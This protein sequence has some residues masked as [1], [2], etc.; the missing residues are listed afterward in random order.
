[1]D[2]TMG[3]DYFGHSRQKD[4]STRDAEWSINICI[5]EAGCNEKERIMQ[6]SA[7]LCFWQCQRQQAAVWIRVHQTRPS[8]WGCGGTCVSDNTSTAL[9]TAAQL[10]VQLHPTYHNC[11]L[12]YGGSISMLVCALSKLV[13]QWNIKGETI[14]HT[15]TL[16]H[17]HT[18]AQR[19][20]AAG[21]SIAS[22]ETRHPRLPERKGSDN[23]SCMSCRPA[24]NKEEIGKRKKKKQHVCLSR[25]EQT[26]ETYWESC[27]CCTWR[28]GTH[29][30]NNMERLCKWWNNR[31]G[32][33][34][35]S[36][37]QD[38]HALIVVSVLKDKAGVILYLSWQ[39]KW[40]DENHL[41]FHVR[42]F[43]N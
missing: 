33:N 1:M 18:P 22:E 27:C 5:S 30:T 8:V 29:A 13:N 37:H 36:N 15:H 16:S 4:E 7:P 17:T 35:H 41:M 43:L 2:K 10:C 24:T 32:Q 9:M 39:S 12:M 11:L 42:L 31:G 6:H 40:E 25:A 14:K 20:S 38:Y 23:Q 26:R 19:G 3:C 34:A 28:R 21:V